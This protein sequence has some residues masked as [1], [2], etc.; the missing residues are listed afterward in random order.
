MSDNQKT[1]IDLI[2]EEIET[3]ESFLKRHR[4]W[5]T[6]SDS[7]IITHRHRSVIDA[8]NETIISYHLLLTNIEIESNNKPRQ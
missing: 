1:K 3:L 7:A 5:G 2:K 4:E 8:M 6:D